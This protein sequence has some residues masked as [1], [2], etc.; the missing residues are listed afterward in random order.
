MNSERRMLVYFLL[1]LV[2]VHDGLGVLAGTS[3]S[4]CSCS[5]GSALVLNFSEEHKFTA[6][7]MYFLLLLLL[8]PWWKKVDPSIS[9]TLEAPKPEPPPPA[10]EDKKTPSKSGF[11]SLFKSKVRKSESYLLECHEVHL[12][13]YSV[14]SL[15]L[16]LTLYFFSHLYEHEAK[17]IN[18]RCGLCVCLWTFCSWTELTWAE[19]HVV[20]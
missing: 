18:V 10:E 16:P 12:L 4:S 2:F 7:Y 8:L 3:P 11:M 14:C 20:I 19:L 15:L 9:G 13:N 1:L 5:A 17:L 6:H